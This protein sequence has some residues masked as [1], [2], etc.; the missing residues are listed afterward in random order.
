MAVHE[1]CIDHSY[2]ANGAQA[3]AIILP[4]GVSTMLGWPNPAASA[5][6]FQRREIVHRKPA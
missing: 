1:E 4:D 6:P 2:G 5:L 3:Q